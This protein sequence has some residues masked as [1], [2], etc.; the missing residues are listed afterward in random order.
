VAGWTGGGGKRDKG[1]QTQKTKHGQT[2]RL[3]LS[4]E[5]YGTMATLVSQGSRRH[6]HPKQHTFDAVTFFSRY[7][8]TAIRGRSSSLAADSGGAQA[9]T[10]TQ[11][12]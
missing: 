11:T 4:E 2:T 1:V 10:D 9:R 3:A 7:I 6:V 8:P 5:A 12:Q